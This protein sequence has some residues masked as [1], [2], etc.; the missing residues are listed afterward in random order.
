MTDEQRDR[1]EFF[2]RSHFD[3]EVIKKVSALT[4]A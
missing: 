2:T 3:K 4:G 1:F